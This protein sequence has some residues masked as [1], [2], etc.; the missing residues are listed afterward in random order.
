MAL[1]KIGTANKIKV[2][3]TEKDFENFLLKRSKINDKKNRNFNNFKS[4]S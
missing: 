4:N 3:K 2:I 1:K